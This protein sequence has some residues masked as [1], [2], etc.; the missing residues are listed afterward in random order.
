MSGPPR[1]IVLKTNPHKVH[2]VIRLDS[3]TSVSNAWIVDRLAMGHPSS[4]SHSTKETL[5]TT[6]KLG[7]VLKC[8]I[9]L[10]F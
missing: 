10:Q 1:E 3:Y 8:V 7:K 6:Q 9:G 5:K 4:V 2:L